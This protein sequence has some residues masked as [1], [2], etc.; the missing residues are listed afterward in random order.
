MSGSTCAEDFNLRSTIIAYAS[1]HD[2][3]GS[4]ISAK[5]RDQLAA[6]DVKW[7][8][9]AYDTTI[10]TAAANGRIVL[11]DIN[12]TGV[13]LARLHEH[14]RQ[15]HKV[16]F[17]PHKGNFLLSG[18]QD[19]TIRL[20]DLRDLTGDRS[21]M[22]CRSVHRY[23]GNNEGIRDLRW[24]PTDGVEFAA[25][26]DN[27]VIQRWDLRKVN[28]PLL[29]INAHEKTC[30]SVDWHPDGKHLVSG[31]ADKSVKVWNFTSTDRRMKPSYHLRAPQAVLNARWR[32]ACWTTDGQG[33][34][35][36]QCTHLATSY[37][38]HDPRIHIWDFRRPYM[39]FR[40][41]DRY[42][43]P[44]TDLLWHSDDLL[45]TVG[46]AGM[47]TQTDIHFAPKVEDKR[48][49]STVTSAPNGQI[50]FFAGIRPQRRRSL[51]DSS[52]KL[53][54]LSKRSGTGDK[55]SGSHSTTDG[56]LEEASL[57]SSSFKKRHQKSASV[58]SSK[59]LSST[60]PSINGSLPVL[61]FDE[62]MKK[63]GVYQNSQVAAYGHVIG[64]F[65][66]RAFT[67]L[68][69]N[70]K[71]PPN[72]PELQVKYDL[73]HEL[74]ELF[75]GNA[76]LAARAG[77]YRL[78]QS[79]RI[80]A[81]AVEKELKRRANINPY[82]RRLMPPGWLDQTKLLAMER[83]L[84]KITLEK[85][86]TR[87]KLIASLESSSNLSTPLARP[88]Q[89][90]SNLANIHETVQN[91]DV[92]ESQ[93]LPIP[94]WN[95]KPKEVLGRTQYKLPYLNADQPSGISSDDC[96]TN[97]LESQG[98]GLAAAENA[99]TTFESPAN[100]HPESIQTLPHLDSG[101]D[102]DG[103]IEERRAAMGSYRSKPRPLLRLDQPLQLSDHISSIP[104]LDRHD[105][106]ESFQMFSAST[107]SSHRATSTAG[108][109]NLGSFNS[110]QRSDDSGPVPERWDNSMRPNFAIEHSPVSNVLGPPSIKG[111]DQPSPDS[112]Q[113]SPQLDFQVSIKSEEA[114]TSIR[115][116]SEVLRPTTLEPPIVHILNSHPA[117]SAT[118]PASAQNP[119]EKDS[120]TSDF[121]VPSDFDNP[122]TPLQTTGSNT[123]TASSLG[124]LP[125]TASAM[126]PRIISYHTTNLSD[127]QL[128]SFLILYLQPYFDPF[129]TNSIF[130][131]HYCNSILLTYHSQLCG[132][133]LYV[134]A[135]LLRK[136][137]AKL[138]YADVAEE[139]MLEV[140]GGGAWCTTCR[141]TVKGKKRGWCER[142]KQ[143]WGACAICEGDGPISEFEEPKKKED[144]KYAKG[145][146]ALWSWCQ[147]CGHGG[148]GG[149]LRLWWADAAMSE[150]GCATQGCLCDCVAGSRRDERLKAIEEQQKAKG[151]GVRRDT[152]T[153]GE[154]KA[155]ERARGVLGVGQAAT[156]AAGLMGGGGALSAGIT[157]G[158]RVRLVV[159]E[160]EAKGDVGDGKEVGMGQSSSSAP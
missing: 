100:P 135:A 58:R 85:A 33:P 30:H 12:R 3:A 134:E 67:F 15:V 136:Q 145:A 11:Y 125:W 151:K 86:R 32:P 137:C 25:G 143:P 83:R 78:A 63:D 139:G 101:A 94:L 49:V 114:R 10:A 19:A 31:G 8:H 18:S 35:N 112:P 56:S 22:T 6:N 111:L 77:Q 110:V 13:E 74:F 92:D 148:H 34:G 69:R 126:L 89:D 70:Y 81:L 107:D 9:G 2:P 51:E 155:V 97:S 87:E 68:A 102:I 44:A 26:T 75:G 127:F 96:F 152:W 60:P 52:A 129:G 95:V 150:G 17:N 79:W 142:C 106:N 103:I 50:C 20:W 124:E 90:T 131:Y 55:L 76:L 39:P 45:W 104:R 66:A 41:L 140:R 59:S 133:K 91:L 54:E 149:C 71:Q 121:S 5:S 99:T 117:D 116:S 46:S 47:F 123:V 80:L 24:S 62:A 118:V 105:S 109:F 57:L 138:G 141:K 28:A 29:K 42:D 27:G 72:R 43:V 119:P 157:G 146:A 38:H 61:K 23:P 120:T 158:K 65:D 122:P 98:V 93:R 48:G 160:E 156:S 115:P 132:L 1:T 82:A 14:N 108:S 130:P 113:G 147:R 73:H 128:P 144:V 21:V 153:V 16:A 88:L 64:V 4:V 40:E 53:L 84:E 159:P 36:W 37:D 7:S 154:S